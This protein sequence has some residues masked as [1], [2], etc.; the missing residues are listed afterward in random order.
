MGP[1][2]K[3]VLVIDAVFFAVAAVAFTAAGLKAQS[4]RKGPRRPGQFTLCFLLA[5]LGL[6]FVLLSGAAQEVENR[7]FPNLGR[8]LSNVCTLLAALGLVAHLLSI[9]HPPEQARPMIRRRLLAYAAAIAVMA[10]AFLS[11]SAPASVGGFGSLYAANVALVVYVDIYIVLLGKAMIDLLVVGLRYACHTRRPALRAGL[12]I[13]AVGSM[14][15][16]AYLGEKAFFVQAQA[17]GLA[18]P[19]VGRDVV[20]ASL[21]WPVRCLFSVT[22]PA[23]AVLLIV[24]GMTLPTWGP[25]LASPV[26]SVKDRRLYRRL[27]PLWRVLYEAFPQIV[28]PGIA[29]LGARWKLQRR[30]IEIHDGLLM[31]SPYR[32]AGLREAVNMAAERAGFSGRERGAVVE[33]ALIALALEAYRKEAPAETRDE[34]TSLSGESADLTGEACRLAVIVDAMPWVLKLQEQAHA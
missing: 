6:S 34:N 8:L 22:F 4:M 15:A 14:I 33:A 28:M 13:V 11:D 18:S 32:A 2:A 26:R 29:D 19:A 25:V 1:L 24:M 5:M 12:G 9:S 20:C 21:V 30:V 17:F 7:V 10:G 16:L 3:G 31:L 23:V 27:E